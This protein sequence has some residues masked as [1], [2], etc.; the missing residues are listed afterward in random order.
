MVKN[1]SVGIARTSLRDAARSLLPLNGKHGST[2][3]TSRLET[4]AGIA[5]Y[6]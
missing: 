2:P 3:L 5:I 6:I 4:T 1:L